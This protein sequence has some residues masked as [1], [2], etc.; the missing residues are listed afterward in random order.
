LPGAVALLIAKGLRLGPVIKDQHLGE[1]GSQASAKRAM[2]RMWQVGVTVRFT[3]EGDKEAV[4]KAI[5]NAFDAH[6]SAP[7]KI[8]NGVDLARQG[9]KGSFDLLHLFPSC[10][11]FEF[12]ENNMP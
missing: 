7:F 3:G 12:E 9:A 6:I 8:V 5:G 10:A 2:G 1:V 11:L 4:S